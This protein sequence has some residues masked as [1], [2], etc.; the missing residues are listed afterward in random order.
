ME[1]TRIK[2]VFEKSKVFHQ[3]NKLCEVEQMTIAC[4]MM[5]CIVYLHLNNV[6]NEGDEKGRKQCEQNLGDYFTFYW[7][8]HTISTMFHP[9]N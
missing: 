9:M 4:I 2:N 7:L 6:T 8:A 1:K 3:Q 5:Y